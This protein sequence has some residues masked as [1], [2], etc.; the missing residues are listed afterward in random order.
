MLFS[1]PDRL[2][3]STCVSSTAAPGSDFVLIQAPD[4][5]YSAN[6]QCR[7]IVITPVSLLLWLR[8]GNKK[9]FS[10]GPLFLVKIDSRG[11]LIQREASLD[12]GL[13]LIGEKFL[14]LVG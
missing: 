7:T 13:K 8:D 12:K 1:Q 3:R 6:Q 11:N 5:K 10:L 9:D 4:A 14:D 2:N